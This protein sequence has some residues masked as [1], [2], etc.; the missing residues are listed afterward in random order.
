MWV[1]SETSPHTSPSPAALTAFFSLYQNISQLHPSGS[2]L[3]CPGV[4]WIGS[5]SRHEYGGLIALLT[6]SIVPDKNEKD[7]NPVLSRCRLAAQTALTDAL[8][9]R[10][11]LSVPFSSCFDRLR[12]S[13]RSKLNSK[14]CCTVCAVD[15]CSHHNSVLPPVECRRET[16]GLLQFSFTERRIVPIAYTFGV[17]E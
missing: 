8:I 2:L 3:L 5:F 6:Q 17:S 12:P 16:N 14:H 15:L 13:T 9:Y 11:L 10:S 4:P 1:A 7:A